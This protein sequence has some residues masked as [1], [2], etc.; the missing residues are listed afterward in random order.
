LAP[1]K[2]VAVIS[3]L[4]LEMNYD[5]VGITVLGNSH[6]A[7]S[8][9][10]WRLNDLVLEK[11]SQLLRGRF[12][13]EAPHLNFTPAQSI[14]ASEWA[15]SISNQSSETS[16]PDLYIIVE[17]QPPYTKM[18]VDLGG[19]YLQK[20]YN[21]IR[22]EP[23]LLGVWLQFT[24]IDGKTL[25]VIG[26]QRGLPKGVPFKELQDFDWK[27][28]W[29]DLTDEQRLLIRNNVRELIDSSIQG[30]FEKIQIIH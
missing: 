3:A 22:T 26:T 7:V 24:L 23:P 19:F 2:T 16:R 15:A 9:R 1:Q 28:R 10:D 18:L 5:A 12:A 27:D 11:A 4:P 17:A 29:E 21:A 20:H 25:K 8:V 13:V 30:T 14:S 6:E